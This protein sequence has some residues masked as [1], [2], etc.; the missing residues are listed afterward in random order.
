MHA[1]P[2]RL[3]RRFRSILSSASAP[4]RNSSATRCGAKVPSAGLSIFV[5]GKRPATRRRPGP[6]DTALHH[7]RAPAADLPGVR[8]RRPRVSDLV[9]RVLDRSVARAGCIARGRPTQCA[10]AA[11]VRW[12]RHRHRSRPTSSVYA[13]EVSGRGDVLTDAATEHVTHGVEWRMDTSPHSDISSFIRFLHSLS[14][15]QRRP[16]A[17]ACAF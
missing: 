13:D 16:T 8:T 17:A 6:G 5:S 12:R 4:A 14:G 7:L 9:R 3:A 2:Q 10:V 11:H 1:D 15:T